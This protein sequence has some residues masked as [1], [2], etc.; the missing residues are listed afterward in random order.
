MVKRC[1]WVS[2]EQI[3]IAYH[4]HEWGVPIYDSQKLFAMLNLEGQQAGLSWITV[5]KKRED[6]YKIFYDFDPE[7]LIK[8]TDKKIQ[9]ILQDPRVIRNKLKVNA[10]VTN[11]KAYLDYQKQHGSF[12]EFIW[13]FNDNENK[14]KINYW[15]KKNPTPAFTPESDQMSKALKKLGFKFV[16]STI[17][18]AFMQAVGMVDDHDASCFRKNMH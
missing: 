5:L 12:S 3:Y 1:S 14:P 7:K 16:G 4:D 8:F 6:Y 15:S 13:S 2:Q 18:Y 17:C 10:I 9:K 11:A